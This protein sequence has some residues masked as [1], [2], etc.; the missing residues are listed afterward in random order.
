VTA[1]TRP[2]I[3]LLETLRQWRERDGL[4]HDD[5]R[6][7]VSDTPDVYHERNTNIWYLPPPY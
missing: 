1:L 7:H 2:I 5:Y 6:L 3:W 4:P